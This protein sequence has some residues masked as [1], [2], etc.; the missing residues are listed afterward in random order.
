YAMEFTTAVQYNMPIKFVLLNNN[1]IGKISKEQRGVKVP[2][3]ST[4]LVN[5]N[6][7]QFAEMCGGWGVRVESEGELK[8]ALEELAALDGP[9][10]LEVMT[11]VLKI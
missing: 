3:W 11:D 8:S 5:P 1:E 4:S 7:A 9:G 6:F 2:V 10:I